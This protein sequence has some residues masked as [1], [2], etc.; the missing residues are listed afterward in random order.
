M[1]S[2]S[3]VYFVFG[4]CGN[5]GREGRWDRNTFW[6]LRCGPI[7]GKSQSCRWLALFRFYTL[8]IVFWVL[9]MLW[10][11]NGDG[12]IMWCCM[13]SCLATRSTVSLLQG[14]YCRQQRAREQAGRQAIPDLD[15]PSQFG[16][17]D[18]NKCLAIASLHRSLQWWRYICKANQYE[19]SH[20]LIINKSII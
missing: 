7:F 16:M 20:M 18:E 11:C 10:T 6:V 5:G 8:S 2:G 13:A 19:I 14:I 1:V 9:D 4:F 12:R 3:N 17:E 15:F